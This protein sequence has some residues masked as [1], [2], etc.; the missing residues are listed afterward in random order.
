MRERKSI[1][2]TLTGHFRYLIN[3]WY[4]LDA[5][6]RRRAARA[7]RGR[8]VGDGND[9]AAWP[10][11]LVSA[12]DRRARRHQVRTFDKIVR[13][14]EIHAFRTLGILG[15]KRDITFAFRNRIGDLARVVV[16]LKGERQLQC[17]S[18]TANEI[19][20]NAFYVAFAVLDCEKGGGRRRGDNAAAK[21][22]SGCK[23]LEV[24]GP[25]HVACVYHAL[26]R[27]TTV[28][29]GANR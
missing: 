19:D 11:D 26:A 6:I 7:A 3:A 28:P 8:C 2:L 12:F 10:V 5:G 14:N 22:S 1:A 29:G 23:L 4:F 21:F 15:H 24:F 13:R 9:P 20:R 16:N 25:G 17:S 18:K 27:R